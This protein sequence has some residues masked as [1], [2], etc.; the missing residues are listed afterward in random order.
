MPRRFGFSEIIAPVSEAVF[1]AESY[2]RGHRVVARGDA[3]YYAGLL[4]LDTVM[5]YIETMPIGA[6]SITMVK[7][8]CDQQSSDYLGPD[9]IADPRRVLA[10][11]QDGWTISLN[12]MQN[13]LPALASL[14]QAVSAQFSARFQTNLY[15]TP[16]GAQGFKPHWDTHDVFVLQVHG[17]KAWSIYDTK[18]ALPLVGQ[19]FNQQQQD[20]GPI[21]DEF[22]LRQGDMLYCPRGLMHAAHSDADTSLHIT[23]GLMGK[24][25]AELMLEAVASAALANPDL[26]RHLPLGFARDDFNP[27]DAT[28]QFQTLLAGLADHID[29]AAVLGQMRD[30]FIASQ[31]PSV[32]GLASQLA[33]LDRITIDSSAQA[34]PD[35]IYHIEMTGDTL[36]V[37]FGSNT[38]TLP[39]F[40]ASAM[41]VALGGTAYRIGDLPGFLDDDGKLILVRRLI[42]E[43]LVVALPRYANPL[44]TPQPSPDAPA[45]DQG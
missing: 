33:S 22:V 43:G 38:L 37:N 19:G 5:Q 21:S 8:G 14:C 11:F 15:L 25:W 26:R 3:G 32:A 44:F 35:L 18:I 39:G 23:F 12:R 4:D 7:F 34:R 30:G 40:T 16:P 45:P 13:H 27:A 41:G 29:F 10:M 20:P 31:V 9:R 28:A 2:E 6:D 1:F 36:T 24:S 17:A 42:R